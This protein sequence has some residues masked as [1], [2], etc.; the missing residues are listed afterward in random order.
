[1]DS[2]SHAPTTT[3]HPAEEEA[4]RSLRTIAEAL[5]RAP[6]VELDL[7]DNALGEKG[8][9]AAAAAFANQV[10][11]WQPGMLAQGKA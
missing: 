8:I 3:P 5:S 4:L 2:A 1:M 10:S 7:S 11:G 6:L 9:R